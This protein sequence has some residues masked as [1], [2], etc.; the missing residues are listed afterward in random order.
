[1]KAKRTTVTPTLEAQIV[2]FRE[3]GYTN[4]AI[5]KRLGLGV[6]TVQRHLAISGVKKGSLKSELIDVAREEAL[7]LLRS[8]PAIKQAIA[9]L[10]IDDIAHVSHVR[11]I[12]VE[13]S[14]H[15]RATDVNSAAQVMRGAAA[16]STAL[17]NTSDILQ[18]HFARDNQTEVIDLPELTVQE[19]T[20]DQVE[21]LRTRH[22][23]ASNVEEASEISEVEIGS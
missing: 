3:A 14:E 22:L 9:Q 19:L 7:L 8:D 6:R 17:K 20:A 4:L 10:L 13:A 5:A 15:L 21:D 2:A 16:Y 18:K 11:E 23:A 12:L 1:M